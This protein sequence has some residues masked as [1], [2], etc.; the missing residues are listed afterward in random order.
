MNRSVV[1][2][3]VFI[4]LFA[5]DKLS[6]QESSGANYTNAI[7]L[8]AGEI[9]GITFNYKFDERNSIKFIVGVFPDASLKKSSE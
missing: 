2:T 3:M 8:R 5:I 9:S 4:C 7:G 1:L 6:A